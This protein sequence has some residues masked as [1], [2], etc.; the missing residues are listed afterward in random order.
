MEAIIVILKENRMAV[1]PVS[2]ILEFE[3]ASFFID[4]VLLENRFRK[5]LYK[6]VY[7]CCLD[8]DIIFTYFEF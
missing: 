3:P 8:F 5:F 1:D 7:T 4:I 6:M 2:K